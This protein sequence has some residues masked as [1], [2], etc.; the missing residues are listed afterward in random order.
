[1]S[2]LRSHFLTH[3][4]NDEIEDYLRRSSVIL[5]PVGVTEMH[6]GFPVDCETVISEAFTLRIAQATDTLT[7]SGLNFFYA[8]ATATGRGTI[9]VSIRQ[10]IDYLG[11]VARDLRRQGFTKQVY[12]SM[13]A[14]AHLTIGPMLRDFCDETDVTAIQIDP[15]KYLG[16]KCRDLLAEAGPDWFH[17]ITVGAY[18]ILGRLADVPLTYAYARPVPQSHAHLEDLFSLSWPSESAGFHCLE[19]SDHMPTPAILTEADR[20]IRAQRGAALI[21]ELVNRIDMP[22]LLAKM[23]ELEAYNRALRERYPHAPGA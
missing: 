11:A 20:D 8:G 19:K 1:M 23:D 2:T 7:L 18:Q 12:F 14:P 16:A 9:Q 17:D 6:G 3:L 10:G 21:D 5:V 22:H 13:H 4:T 15:L